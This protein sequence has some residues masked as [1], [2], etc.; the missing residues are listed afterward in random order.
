MVKIFGPAEGV[1]SD[2]F[3]VS[4][5]SDAWS[6]W[7][8]CKS[9]SGSNPVNLFYVEH[10]AGTSWKPVR[11][12]AGLEHY[13]ENSVAIGASSY[14]TPGSSIRLP[15]PAS[16]HMHCAGTDTSGMSSPSGLGSPLEPERHL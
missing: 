5:A 4:G 11:V 12:P 3:A 15:S 10:S 14:R 8:A 16:G 6:T 9:C 7:A 1:W 2:T 13:A